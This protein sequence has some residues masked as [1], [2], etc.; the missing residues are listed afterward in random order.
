M[1]VESIGHENNFIV[2]TFI[3]LPVKQFSV[4]SFQL[5]TNQLQALVCL[6][7]IE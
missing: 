1:V 2:Y 3:M 6:E 5:G 7:M 4:V